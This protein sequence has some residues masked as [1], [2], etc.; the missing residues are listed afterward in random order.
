MVVDNRLP[1]P[2]RN[3][4]LHYIWMGFSSA[5]GLMGTLAL[6]VHLCRGR[7]SLASI[8][9]VVWWTFIGVGFSGGAVA[10]Y[11]LWV[12]GAKLP[13]DAIAGAVVTGLLVGLAVTEFTLRLIDKERQIAYRASLQD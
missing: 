11:L 9:G 7:H 4:L 3:D 1:A 5:L 8:P 6:V 13:E 10:G 2:S 12:G